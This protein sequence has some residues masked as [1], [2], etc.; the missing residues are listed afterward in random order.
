MSMELMVKAMKI[1]VGN[2]LRKLVL[3]KLADNA[4]DTGECWP[5]YRHI[6][7]QCEISRRSVVSHIDAL[8]EAGLLVKEVR[9]GGAKGNKSNLYHLRLDGAGVAPPS[10]GAAPPSAGVAPP[11]SAGAAP[12]ISHSFE[13]VMEP[14]DIAPHGE[15]AS[16][17]QSE[18]AESHQKPTPKKPKTKPKKPLDY[19]RWPDLPSEQVLADWFESRKNLRAAVTQTVINRLA[20]E[21]HKAAQAG[22]SVDDCL[23]LAC[24]RGWRGLKAEWVINANNQNSGANHAISRPAT[25]QQQQRAEVDA[26]INNWQDTSWADDLIRGDDPGY[27]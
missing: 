20:T 16:E 25:Q 4:S 27:I 9:K 7:D 6:A 24:E 15:S 14:K 18:I 5:S 26:A 22:F 23:G 2:P 12:R 10:A 8:Q 13:P 3:I 1:K 19:S 17:Q 11:P 21:L